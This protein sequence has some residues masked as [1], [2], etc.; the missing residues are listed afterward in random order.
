M[1]LDVFILATESR[2]GNVLYLRCPIG[3]PLA[4]RDHG[5]P[6]I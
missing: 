3:Q 2:D 6:D 4:T 1:W 5:P